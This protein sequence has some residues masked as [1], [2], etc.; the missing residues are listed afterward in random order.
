[1]LD[2]FGGRHTTD[3]ADAVAALEKAV[4]AV[5]AHRPV[6]TALQ[7]ALAADPDLIAGHALYGLAN[8]VLARSETLDGARRVLN[9]AEA[10]CARRKEASPTERALVEALK[11]SAAGRMRDAASSLDRHLTRHPD[12]FLALKLSHAFHFMSGETDA[13]LATTERALPAWSPANAGYGFVLGCHAFGLEERG[14]FAIAEKVGRMAYDAEPADAWGLHAVSHVLEMSH[15]VGEGADLLEAARPNWTRC[16]NFSFHMAWHLALFR[17]EQGETDA[18]LELYDRDIRATPTDDFRDMANAA[19]ILW[20]LELDGVG[21]GDRW[22]DLRDIAFRR[23]RDMSYVFA[24]LHYLLVLVANRDETG[25]RDL[26]T[27]LESQAAGSTGDQSEVAREI[28]VPLARLIESFGS[29]PARASDLAAMAERLP[30]IGGSH[31][32]R[33]VFLRTLLVAADRRGETRDLMTLTR[34][35]HAVRS[36]DR[37]MTL[38]LRRKDGRTRNTLE[39]RQIPIAS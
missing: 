23:R 12:D 31:A 20:R 10:A 28:G 2:R 5:A 33:D 32:Q 8:V 9:E 39:S 4:F 18:V 19:S 17:L 13:M 11:S 14:H 30:S 29:G 1:M 7:D 24:T 15:R 16:N 3:S 27:A 37:F 6:G 26:M 38:L 34:V 25:V 22:H 36:W 35:R 21:V